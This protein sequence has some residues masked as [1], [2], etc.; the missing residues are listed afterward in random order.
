[1]H[2][3]RLLEPAMLP[4]YEGLTFPLFRPRLRDTGRRAG[5][6]AVGSAGPAGPTGL[7]LAELQPGGE[8]AELL[9]IYV[10]PGQRR[11][12]LGTV[13][14]RHLEDALRARRCKAVHGTYM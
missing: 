7:A 8:A 9:S 6:I 4:D 3:T 12:G 14:L 5:L 10:R 11:V 13:L 1:M 2:A